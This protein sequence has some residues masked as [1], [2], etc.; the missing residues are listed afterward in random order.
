MLNSNE[1][2]MDFITYLTYIVVWFLGAVYGWY[3]RER[4][5]KRTVDRLFSH[6]E[7]VVEKEVD[8]SIIHISIEK[9]NGMFFVYKK[10]TNEFMG[11]G[12]TKRELEQNLAKRFPEKKF[13]ADKENLRILN[14]SI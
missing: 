9:H 4:H 11:Q 2:T 10:D 7:Q 13:A 1:A 6:V 14:E 8:D 5:A 12:N 3:A